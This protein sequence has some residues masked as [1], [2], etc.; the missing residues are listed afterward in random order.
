MEEWE[1][2]CGEAEGTRAVS[3][4]DALRCG[5]Y[6]LIPPPPLPSPLPHLA[7]AHDGLVDDDL[8]TLR[9]LQHTRQEPVGL[10]VPL[11]E[12]V[13]RV[14]VVDPERHECGAREEEGKRLSKAAA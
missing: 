14:E 8:R 2:G 9:E 1:G 12:K 3:G 6:F 13:E 7:L 10:R 5:F 11:G 4:A